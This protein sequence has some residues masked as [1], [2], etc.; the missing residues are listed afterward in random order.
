MRSTKLKQLTQQILENAE[1]PVS[2]PDILEALR[3]LKISANKTTIYRELE[4][5]MQQGVI[6]ELDFGEGKKRYEVNQKHH[7]HLICERCN[8]VEHIELDELEDTL[9]TT[10]SKLSNQTSFKVTHH[11]LELFGICKGCQL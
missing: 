7:H 1:S 5:L 2:V 10:Q 8:T 9:Q 4:S 11:T 3:V 6:I